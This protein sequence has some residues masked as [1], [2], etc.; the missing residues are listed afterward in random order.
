MKKD[1]LMKIKVLY[2]DGKSICHSNVSNTFRE[3][4][5]YAGLERVRDLGIIRNTINIVCN[6][7]E[8]KKSQGGKKEYIPDEIKDQSQALM[9]CTQFSTNDKFRYLQLINQNLNLNL[10]ISL[11]DTISIVNNLI[12]TNLTE[13]ECKM[14]VSKHFERDPMARQLCIQYYGNQY[15]CEICGFNF[16]KFYGKREIA[17]PYIEVHHI[18]P[19]A[20]RAKEGGYEINYKNELIP[21]C[22]NCHRMIHN[23]G[24]GVLTPDQLREKLSI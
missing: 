9:V 3:V 21:L 20:L 1:E 2:P 5:E 8:A 15:R 11:N 6:V 18:N 4:I 17:E 22:A 23:F 14:Y 7:D 16:E 10:T 12:P 24:K 19:I 13:G